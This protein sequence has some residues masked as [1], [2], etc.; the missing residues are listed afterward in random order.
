L[1]I[2]GA[3]EEVLGAVKNA[4]LKTIAE[5]GAGCVVGLLG[6]SR[7]L[8]WMYRNHRALT[9]SLLTGFM[10][11]SLQKLWPWQAKVELLHVHSSGKEDWLRANVLPS[12]FDGDA[13]TL[14]VVLAGI[15]GALIIVAVDRIANRKAA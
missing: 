5:F 1:L 4:E 8:N 15:A 2:L 12:A 14:Q 7:V 11:G 9:V 13:H 6:F 10:L 3:Y